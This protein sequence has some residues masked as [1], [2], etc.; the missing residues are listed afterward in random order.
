MAVLVPTSGFNGSGWVALFGNAFFFRHVAWWRT[1]E[2][3]TNLWRGGP[4]R[5]HS[6]IAGQLW[7]VQRTAG[8]SRS[9]ATTAV[10][11]IGV[12]F[13]REA[14]IL[15][16]HRKGQ[17]SWRTLTSLEATNFDVLDHVFVTARSLALSFSGSLSIYISLSLYIYNCIYISSNPTK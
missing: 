3:Q 1:Q 2:N 7:T 13:P 16:P 17:A 11:M 4:H 12:S 8:Q 10:P 5:E 14:A 6:V 9:C 15:A